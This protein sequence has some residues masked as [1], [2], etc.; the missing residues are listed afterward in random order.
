MP[1]QA[2]LSTPFPAPSIYW[3]KFK[4]MRSAFE[5]P[6]TQ[7]E[8][9]CP[10]ASYCTTLSHK[11]HTILGS[12]WRSATGW[13]RALCKEVFIQAVLLWLASA[14]LLAHRSL[15]VILWLFL[16]VFLLESFF[17]HIYYAKVHRP[18]TCG[19][20][21][22]KQLISLSY[23]S[24]QL[25]PVLLDLCGIDYEEYNNVKWIPRGSKSAQF[26]GIWCHRCFDEELLT[27]QCCGVRLD[28]GWWTPASA[29]RKQRN[30]NVEVGHTASSSFSVLSLSL[31]LYLY[32]HRLFKS[33]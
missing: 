11:S 16:E 12:I 26:T 31:S 7:C 32:I 8:S 21:K 28:Q 13:K 5:S 24:T 18:W 33:K 14:S 10:V 9:T 20:H 29:D 30:T 25:F 15:L 4:P 23:L 6:L 22:A 17:R 2:F 1:W 19:S 3:I 27:C